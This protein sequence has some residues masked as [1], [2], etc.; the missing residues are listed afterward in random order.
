MF[1]NVNLNVTINGQKLLTVVSV[2]VKNEGHNIGSECVVTVPLNCRID[3]NNT[4]GTY[5]TEQVKNLFKVG[6]TIKITAWY[7]GYNTVTVFD[8]VV[9]GF[10]LGTPTQIKCL[11]YI[12]YLQK[13]APGFTLKKGTFRQVLEKIV[14][15]TP[16]TIDSRS[17]DFDIQNLTLSNMS[18][19]AALQYLREQMTMLCMTL[20]GSVLYVNLADFKNKTVTYASNINVLKAD[21]QR[22]DGTY[23]KVSINVDFNNKNG[24][25][26][27]W[28][29]GSDSSNSGDVH[30]LSLTN[31]PY[32]E[33]LYKKFAAAAL[34][35]AQRAG[36]HGMVET[37]LYPDCQLFDT[38]AYT[39]ISY[40]ERNADYFISGIEIILDKSGFHRHLRW[41]YLVPENS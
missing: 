2:N 12:Y 25:K 21:L 36:Y 32:D 41:A 24:T 20:N 29:I 8:G 37:L 17:V 3:N 7:D 15:G 26:G 13:D 23:Q 35:D 6:D 5:I 31:V 14:A 1:F 39:D 16:V 28:K 27:K 22:P 34:V 10:V 19:A 11:D 40:P 38:V 33:A 4:D 9:H 18:P 30:K